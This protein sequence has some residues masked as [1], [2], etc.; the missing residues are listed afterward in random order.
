LRQVGLYSAK[1]STGLAYPKTS[2]GKNF[3]VVENVI[4]GNCLELS[5]L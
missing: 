5:L 2:S 3:L 4:E 1:L